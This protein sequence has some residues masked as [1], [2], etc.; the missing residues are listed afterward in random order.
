MTTGATPNT[1][2]FAILMG[3]NKLGK[4]IY[5]GTVDAGEIEIRRKKNR[6]ARIARR[7]NRN[8]KREQ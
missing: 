3:L 6:L 1:F 4:H 7:N 2:Q 8:N 5:G